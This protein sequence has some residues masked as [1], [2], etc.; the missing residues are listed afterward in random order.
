MGEKNVYKCKN[1]LGN[2]KGS[3]FEKMNLTFT[4]SF[5]CKKNIIYNYLKKKKHLDGNVKHK[6]KTLRLYC[7]LQ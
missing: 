3:S 5:S 4:K 7:W 2:F 1:L 6:A